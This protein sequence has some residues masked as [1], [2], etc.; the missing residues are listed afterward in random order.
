MAE[1][2]WRDI[3]CIGDS[4][5]IEVDVNATPG[6]QFQFR[7]KSRKFDGVKTSDDWT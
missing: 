3:T 2:N 5:I 1:P 4:Y 7:H 6:S